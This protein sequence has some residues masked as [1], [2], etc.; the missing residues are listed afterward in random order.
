MS[1]SPLFRGSVAKGSTRQLQSTFQNGSLSTLDKG[2]VVSVDTSGQID[3]VDVSD[4]NS[5]LGIVGVLGEDTPSA[6]SGLVVDSGRVEDVSM[7]FSVGSALYL[8]INGDLSDQKPE[9]G[10]GGFD[11]GDFVVFVGVVVKNE[12]NPTLKDIKIMISVI[13]QL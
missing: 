10:V 8:D 6:A 7:A 11:S 5:V 2:T 4:E 13:G 9:I 3:K 1:F 12:F